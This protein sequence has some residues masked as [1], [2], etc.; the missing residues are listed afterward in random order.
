MIDPN[1]KPVDILRLALERE[2]DAFQ[3][4]SEAAGV[5]TDPA[6]KATF[7]EMAEEE[8]RHIQQLEE[9]LDRWYQSDN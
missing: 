8:K 9:E 7:L 3:F 5:S 1:L 6:S 2:R 4:Y